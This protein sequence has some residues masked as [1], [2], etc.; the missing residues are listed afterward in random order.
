MRAG[1]VNVVVA[2][3]SLLGTTIFAE[4]SKPATFEEALRGAEPVADLQ[5]LIEP[6]FAECKKE[7]DLAVRQCVSVRDWMVDR[8]RERTYWAI[9][10]ESAIEWSPYDATEKKQEFTVNGCLACGRPVIIEGKPHFVT[11]R[12][13]KAIK[14]GRAIGLDVGFL[15]VAQPDEK[16]ATEFKQVAQPRLRTQ[17]VFKVGPVWKSGTFDGVTFVPIA[18]RIFDRCNGKVVAS[19]PPT[20]GKI[21]KE[22]VKLTKDASCP[23]ELT[24]EEKHAKEYA[25]LPI[26]LSPKQINAA[27]TPVK[28]R[29]RDCYQ[30][31][32]QAGTATVK[33]VVAG[34]DGKI[35][36]LTLAPPFDKGDTGL[37]IRAALKG[38]TFPKFKDEKMIITY[39]FQLP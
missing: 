26:Q 19:E 1:W 4:E 33:L 13:P 27:L 35:Q 5:Q 7:D 31:F 24:D 29:V 30:E 10:D 23:E 18:Y 15:D 17:F 20:Q 25:A 6:L 2:S 22:A 11:T 32:Q 36:A 3:F 39:P 9:G 16:A 21:A 38:T 8:M 34:G 12:V 28:D 14:S 37:C